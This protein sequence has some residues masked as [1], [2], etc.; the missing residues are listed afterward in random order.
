[1]GNN[2]GASI[3]PKLIEIIEM[4]KDGSL[5]EDNYKL[6]LALRMKGIEPTLEVL[7]KLTKLRVI[8]GYIKNAINIDK[9]LA[10]EVFNYLI[11]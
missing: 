6:F 2:E 4:D 10:K 11:S 5:Y 3:V 7:D 9:E 8:Y 1:M